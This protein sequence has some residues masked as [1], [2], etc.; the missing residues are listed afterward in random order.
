MADVLALFPGQGAQHLGMCNDLAAQFPIVKQT[1]SEASEVIDVDLWSLAQQGPEEKLNQTSYT[2]PILVAA[3][4]AC[5]R[6]VTEQCPELTVVAAAGHSLGEY[7]ALVAAGAIDFSVAVRLVHQRGQL[8][9]AAVPN[10]MGGMAAILGLE[11]E[12]INQLCQQLQPNVVEAANVNAPG[13]VVVAGHQQAVKDFTLIAKQAGARRALPLAVSGPFHSSL[14]RPAAE[15]FKA[16]LDEIDWRPTQFPVLHNF[17]NTV[18]VP[19]QMTEHL[20]AQLYSPVIW[21]EAVSGLRSVASEATTAVEFGS[22]KVLAGLV[23][24]IDKTMAVLSSDTP[25]AIEKLINL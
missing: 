4:T 17:G 8:M 3:S 7:S 18:A 9:E 16:L 22:G 11:L 15:Q 6:V 20:A 19:E 10:G 23:K 2:Q 13:Q 14:M 25:E 5:Y 21:T 12:V 24:R 1:F